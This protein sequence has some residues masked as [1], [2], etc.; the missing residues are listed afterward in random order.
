MNSM[1]LSGLLGQQ[2]Q[3]ANALAKLGDGRAQPSRSSVAGS[4]ASLDFDSPYDNLYAF[5]KIWAGYDEPQNS[6]QQRS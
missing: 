5:G 2:P 4:S 6:H 3:A 1:F